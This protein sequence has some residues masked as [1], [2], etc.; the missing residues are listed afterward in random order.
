MAY[1]VLVAED[2]R[3]ARMLIETI[4]DKSERYTLVQ[5]LESAEGTAELC[6]ATRIDLVLMDVLFPDGLNGIDAARRIKAVS[7]HTKVVIMTSMPEVSY[8]RRA[9]EAGVDSFWYKE[10]QELPLLTLM[11]RTMA[12]EHIYPDATPRLNIG[13]ALSV[14]FTDREIEVLREILRGLT[15]AEIAARLGIS[16]N[17]VKI[18]VA[19]MLEKTGYPNR[20]VLAVQARALGVVV[21]DP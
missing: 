18:H 9:R 8:L 11:D 21:N 13:S 6:R 12:G 14:E 5:S 10:V 19:H 4:L 1:S 2:Q 16:E 20:I 7:P 15:N 3:I 17:T